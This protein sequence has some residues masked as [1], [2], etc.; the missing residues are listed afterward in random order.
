[1]ILRNTHALPRAWLVGEAVS[2]D[3]PEALRRIRGES[4]ADFDPRKTALLETRPDELPKLPGG[5]LA[6]ESTT[7]LLYYEPARLAIETHAQTT[8]MLIVSEM[9]YPGW[10]ARV[11]GQPAQIQVA[12]YLLRAVSLPAGDHRVEMY[13][14]AP[15]ARTGAIISVLALCLLIALV[16][17][18]LRTSLLEKS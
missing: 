1:M 5:P 12:D 16:I 3:S 15:A 18:A 10:R 7:K 2:V 6:S 11:D 13:Y 8:S 9:F 17:R 4:P 14:T